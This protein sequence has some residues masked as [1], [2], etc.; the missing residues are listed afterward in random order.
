MLALFGGSPAV[1]IAAVAVWGFAFGGFPVSVSIWNARAAPDLAESAGAL[2]A[3]S[4]QVA[5]ASG[6]LIGGFLIDGVGPNGVIVYAAA[7][8]VLGAA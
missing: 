8:V 3:S 4:F 1:A 5:I 6:A 2:L 7:A